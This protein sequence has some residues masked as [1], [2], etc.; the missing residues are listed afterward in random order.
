MK[1]VIDAIEAAMIEVIEAGEKATKSELRAQGHYLTGRSEKS[2]EYKIERND[3][4][5]TGILE[6]AEHLIYLNFGVRPENVR[7]PISVMVDYWKK[8]GLPEDEAVRAAWATRNKHR[9]EGIP[10]LASFRFS[11]TGERTG[12]ISSALEKVLDDMGR[13]LEQKTGFI[14]NV[15]IAQDVKMQ[16]IKIFV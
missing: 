3:D 13:I 9:Q 6:G 8:R 11:S 4:S 14:L 10:T 2:I 1:Q 12:F 5:V 7:Y 16:P 15:T